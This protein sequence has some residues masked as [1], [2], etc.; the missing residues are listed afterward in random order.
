ME[1]DVL[2]EINIRTECLMEMYQ[3]L[4][5]ANEEK[6]DETQVNQIYDQFKKKSADMRTQLKEK[7][8]E[9]R[10]IIKVQEQTS[11]AI[12]K[13]NLN[14][15]ES[16]LKNLKSVDYKMFNDADKWIKNAKGKLDSFEA[17][18]NNPNYIAFDMLENAKTPATDDFMNADNLEDDLLNDDAAGGKSYDIITS[19][20]KIAESIGKVKTISPALLA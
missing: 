8:K 16:E 12:L 14:H 10:Q 19:G 7:F 11:E 4:V 13:K 17:N 5:E 9:M 18:N 2:E 3:H 1:Q 6:P 20:E 15:I